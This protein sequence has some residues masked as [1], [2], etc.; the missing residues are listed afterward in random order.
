MISYVFLV[1]FL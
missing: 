1:L